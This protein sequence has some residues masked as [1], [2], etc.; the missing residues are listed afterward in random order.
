M[1]GGGGGWIRVGGQETRGR[2]G[3]VK[4]ERGPVYWPCR[5][6]RGPEYRPGGEGRDLSGGHAEVGA[7]H[8]V[9]RG[10]ARRGSKEQPS[11]QHPV[12]S[13]RRR[14]LHPPLV[15]VSPQS[16]PRRARSE[17]GGNP[18]CTHHGLTLVLLS[19]HS[20]IPFVAPDSSRGVSPQSHSEPPS[21]PWPNP[22]VTLPPIHS[23]SRSHP[24]TW[25]SRPPIQ[26]EG[27]GRMRANTHREH[28]E[29]TAGRT[30][31]IVKLRATPVSSTHAPTRSPTCE[32]AHEMRAQP[33]G[34]HQARAQ[35]DEG[36]VQSSGGHRRERGHR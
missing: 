29:G 32:Q 6:G 9:D 22:G 7:E 11:H 34:S 24:G 23:Y 13:G 4:G 27:P 17:L 16:D 35:L 26:V 18:G 2:G 1:V 12:C 21:P 28:R 10:V 3:D 14:H 19:H 15:S 25:L 30:S 31:H 36:T 33:V 5:R 20:L 8:R